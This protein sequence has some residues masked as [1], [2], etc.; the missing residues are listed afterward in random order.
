MARNV[1]HSLVP[2]LL[3]GSFACGVP[4]GAGNDPKA[5]GGEDASTDADSDGTPDADDCSPDDP[6][7]HPDAEEVCDEIDNDCDG[8]IDEDV[9]TPFFLDADGDGFAGEAHTLEACE[10]PEGYHTDAEDCDDLDPAVHPDA[11]ETCDGVDNDCD[12]L[13]DAEDDDVDDSTGPTWYPDADGDSY[14]VEAYGTAACEAPSG[15]VADAG[16]C[17][18]MDAAL[19]PDTVWYADADGDGF[20]VVAY[21]TTGC[22]QPSGYVA[23]GTDCDDFDDAVH[24]DATEVCDGGVDN[25]CSGDADDADAGVDTS[26]FTDWYTDADSDGYGHAAS[27]TASCSA[28]SGT[29]ATAGDCDDTDATL[30]PGTQWYTDADADGYGDPDAASASCVQP[31]GTVSDASDCDDT[32]AAISPDATE[33]C[34]GGV[35]NDCS[36]D[37]DD[38]DVGVDTSTHTVF[39]ADSDGDGYGDAASSTSAC[40]AP[41]GHAADDSDC[42]DT[43]GSVSPAEVEVCGDGLDND[44]SGDAAG[45]GMGSG[46]WAHTDADHTITGSS[47][48]D[49]FGASIAALDFNGDGYDEIAI[50]ADGDDAN[51]SGGGQVSVFSGISASGDADS[52]ASMQLDA[53]TA[54]GLGSVVASAGDVNADGYEDL[55]VGSS[56]GSRGAFLVYGQPSV[57]GS[58]D[59]DTVAIEWTGNGSYFGSDSFGASVFGLG[60]IDN[61][62][63]DDFAFGAPTDDEPLQAY[64]S[65]YSGSLFLMYGAAS[66]RTGG[67]VHSVS[68]AYF[69]G[70]RASFLGGGDGAVGD[71]D[72]DGDGQTDFFIGC[73][74]MRNGGRYG[75]AFFYYGDG[76]RFSSLGDHADTHLDAEFY[77]TAEHTSFGSGLEAGDID[78]DGYD[79]L[80]VWEPSGSSS[81]SGGTPGIIQVIAGRASPYSGLYS[82]SSSGAFAITGIASGDSFGGGMELADLDD[83]GELDLVVGASGVDTGASSGGAVYV[84]HGPLSAATSASSADT[85]VHGA[86]T[87]LALGAGRLALTDADRDGSVDLLVGGTGY[88]SST[89]ATYLFLGGGM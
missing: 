15:H 12:T 85:T 41:S 19:H 35:D 39:Y 45:C 6:D 62:G 57:A 60:D 31:S 58:V 53:V 24:P 1:T 40:S 52:L 65:D 71:S 8:D 81:S 34:D 75:S 32:D 14:G 11:P 73:R 16:D 33:V 87:D 88:D 44:C 23:E 54:D 26:T 67:V 38:D 49:S 22:A 36:G 9:T 13:V 43:D 69:T 51:V 84:F 2:L 59:I 27:S 86:S 70:S 17:D 28:P 3:L 20:G 83:D 72:I 7:V 74:A 76:S 48:W 18:D 55:L 5:H 63:Y 42:D 77:G 25:D 4:K 89:G 30:H 21:S 68:D 56:V 79:D 46:T 78:G 82:T 37:A 50:G 10:P 64:G 47:T 66:A 80:L 61:D 29:V